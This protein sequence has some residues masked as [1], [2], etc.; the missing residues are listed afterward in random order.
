MPG[1][2]RP[3]HRH[4]WTSDHSGRTATTGYRGHRCPAAAER[5]IAWR[6]ADSLALREFVHRSGLVFPVAPAFLLP[7]WNV[8]AHL[9]TLHPLQRRAGMYPLSATISSMPSTFTFGLS[10][11]CTSAS[12]TASSATVSPA[13]HSADVIESVK[14]LGIKPVHTAYKS[15]W[16]NGIAERFVGNCR[17]DL[18]DQ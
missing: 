13:S 10:S 16:R 9:V 15:L 8:G 1:G 11:G 3:T 12:R 14:L 2:L 18:L 17:R 5:G 6:L 4:D 7:L